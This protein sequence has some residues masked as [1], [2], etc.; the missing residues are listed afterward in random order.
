MAKDKIF[1]QNAPGVIT[2]H[3][4]PPVDMTPEGIAWH[5]EHNPNFHPDLLKDK[6]DATESSAGATSTEQSEPVQGE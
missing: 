6:S 3:I 1:K 2:Y 5:K 4:I